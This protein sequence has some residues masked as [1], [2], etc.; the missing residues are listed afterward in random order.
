MDTVETDIVQVKSTKQLCISS[1]KL[2]RRRERGG[3]MGRGR[4]RGEGVI[5]RVSSMSRV[6]LTCG[7][8][9]MREH[10]RSAAN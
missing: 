7:G 9:R 4:E 5:R 10:N 6:S 3:S 8:E 2:T 1:D